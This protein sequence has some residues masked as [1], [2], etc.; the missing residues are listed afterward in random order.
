[1]RPRADAKVGYSLIPQWD[2]IRGRYDA[3]WRHEG[4]FLWLTA[5]RA[6]APAHGP[7]EGVARP[8]DTAGEWTDPAWRVAKSEKEFASTWY[9]GDAY[10]YFDPQLGPGSLATFI[11]SEPHF[12]TETVW[13]DP[14]IEEPEAHPPLSFD[15]AGRHF[16]TQMAIAEA[17]RAAGRGRY[18]VTLPDLIENVDT[19]V[20]LRGMERLLEDMSDRPGWVEKQVAA[21]NEIWFTVFD[22]MRRT[23]ADPWGGNHWGAFSLWGQGRTAKVQCDA[24]A[25]F[26]PPHFRRFVTPA[27]AEQ[28][29]WL[30]NSLYHLDGTQC[31]CHLD[32]LLSIPDLDAVEWT[33]QA[34]LP[35]GGDSRWHDMYR[36]ILSAG[37]SV[38]AVDVS[39]AQVIPLLDA[40]GPKGLFIHAKAATEEEGRRVEERAEAYRA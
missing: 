39:A 37:K 19:V 36:R 15:P 27:L 10:P 22:L 24:S 34:G 8:R 40:V 14:C 1:M 25:A 17:G 28:C 35:G 18:P 11:G 21:V 33:P 38:Q 13:F 5:P 7:W 2:R 3:W 6:D 9:G 29:R 4:L 23:L 20:S 12:D 30:D 32:E 26:G 16:R 31:I